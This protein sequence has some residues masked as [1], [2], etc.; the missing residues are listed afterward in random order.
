MRVL[1]FL[2]QDQKH[3]TNKLARSHARTR[4][5]T[6]SLTHSRTHLK[7][8]KKKGNTWTKKKSKHEAKSK[9]P[10]LLSF[11]AT[12]SVSSVNRIRLTE[13]PELRKKMMGLPAPA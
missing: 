4:S 7:K 5:L 8:N 9:C 3:D 2:L 13:F 6:H 1:E 11:F 12:G 10:K